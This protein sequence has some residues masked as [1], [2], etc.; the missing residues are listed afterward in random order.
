MLGAVRT[1]AAS[2]PEAIGV[3]IYNLVSHERELAARVFA[4]A[5]EPHGSDGKR[6]RDSL[7]EESGRELAARYT[8]MGVAS[9]RHDG[10]R[11]VGELTAT[12][13]ALAREGLGR[14]PT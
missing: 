6:L 13:K 12:V 2:D 9:G 10:T 4:C 3:L 7:I 8:A 14:S 1:R 11:L 5:L